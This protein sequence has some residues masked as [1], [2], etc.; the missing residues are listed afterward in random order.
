MP[1][2]PDV[3]RTTAIPPADAG[4]FRV[5]VPRTTPP[6]GVEAGCRVIEAGLNGT[7]VSVAVRVSP[8]ALA[9]KFTTVGEATAAVEIGTE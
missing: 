6:A 8:P 4:P 7:T 9:V 3:V 2:G 5:T 1:P